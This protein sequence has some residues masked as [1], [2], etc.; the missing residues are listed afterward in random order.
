MSDYKTCPLKVMNNF[1]FEME[2]PDKLEV[3]TG[4]C[5]ESTCAWWDEMKQC[6][7]VLTIARAARQK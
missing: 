2:K 4:D 6:C 7:A 3:A 1:C 5:T